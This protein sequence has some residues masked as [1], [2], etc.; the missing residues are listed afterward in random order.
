MAPVD[1]MRPSGAVAR[2]EWSKYAAAFGDGATLPTLPAR[3]TK[4]LLARLCTVARMAFRWLLDII[5]F[6]TVLSD[7]FQ[8]RSLDVL[9]LCEFEHITWWRKRKR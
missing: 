3:C 1:S 6:G 2:C 4:W 9:A 8:V 7:R 5:P